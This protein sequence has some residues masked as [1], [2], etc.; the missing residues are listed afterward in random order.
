M[1]KRRLTATLSCLLLASASTAGLEAATAT[2]DLGATDRGSGLENTQ[3]DE[4]TDGE[5]DA[6][7]CG[8]AGREREVRRNRGPGEAADP[9]IYLYFRVAE[10][11]VKS[12]RA[13]RVSATFFDDPAFAASPV[14]VRLQYTNAAA[15]GPADIPD[16][17]ASHPRTWTLGGSGQWVRHVWG[18]ADAGFR[19]FMQ[20]TSDFRLVLGGR[21]C[22]D[23][24]EVTAE[25]EFV[26][27][28]HVIGAHYYPWFDGGRW[29]YGE[30]ASGALRLEL[31]P[32]Q[33][34][35]LGRYSSATP[36]VVDQHLRWCAEHGVNLLILEYI[37]PG[38]REDRNVLDVL[39]RSPRRDDVQYSVLYDWAIRFGELAATPARIAT[40]VQDFDHLAERYF[41]QPT[42]F[43]VRGE[44][45][46]AM[47]YVTR[48]LSGDV[49]GFI[50]AVR[51]VC[52]A[53]GHD[54]FLVGDEFFFIQ[55][56]SA[57][58]IA[59]WDG[60]FGYDVYASRGGYWGENGALDLFRSRT[61]AY[62][63]AARAARVLFI[64]S[65]AP[66][67]NDRAIRRTCADHPA[68]PRQLASGDEPTSL[69]REVF[70]GISL[71]RVDAAVPLV[72]I[73][74][75]NE[76]HEDT[77]IEP[78]AGGTGGTAADSSPS[79]S[80]YTQGFA[81]ADYG[82][83]FLELIRDATIAVTGRVLGIDGRPA[84]GAAVDVLEG[85]S[86]DTVVLTRKA[87][88][89]GIYTIPRLRL[90]P[91]RS[92]RLRVRSP[93]LKDV[94]SEPF[95]PGP[96]TITGFDLAF[97]RNAPPEV[98]IEKPT[99][100]ALFTPAEPIPIA[101]AAADA[102]GTVERVEI[103]AD[104][105]PLASAVE[106]PYE[107][108]WETA[109]EGEHLI[110]A[111]AVDDL[112]EAAADSVTVTVQ[113]ARRLP[114]NC[115]RDGVVD[116]SDGVCVLGFLFAGT[117]AALPCG[118]GEA[119]HPANLALLDWQPDGR[120][121]LSDGVA[122]LQFLFGGGRAHHLA[123]PGEE[124]TTC[125]VIAGCTESGLCP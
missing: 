108:A 34:P 62:V 94:V 110:T 31:R 120:I 104:G 8:P 1:V 63:A 69:F 22:T 99:E 14:E 26:P 89:T 109:A 64:P 113:A 98:E 55:A 30:C 100:G 76:W 66:G 25:G 115:N 71:S 105:D 61:D 49:D 74:S 58:R 52:A 73:T 20:G 97:R 10:P 60:I 70:A 38:G 44:R 51:E 46:L 107:F 103:L 21:A 41:T 92:H 4:G 78:T 42:Y 18:L 67:F 72:S 117:P 23:R 35:R 124:S 85:A 6:L 50:G 87:F 106:P 17:F 81:H 56:P 2:V 79:G 82:L 96:A 29:N 57:A 19:D 45:P 86:G 95:A 28:E 83:A 93:G 116:V 122:L 77:Q 65:C 13:L 101:V 48:A 88:S 59:R 7:T 24:V 102:D 68:L 27:E 33:S 15:T 91:G 12:A 3:R 123:A 9:D 121:D 40:A 43:K 37:A 114:G 111:R 53:R 5:N 32:P 119:T 36:S 112:G 118:D 11:A 39:F 125:V 84:P 75:F 90:A 16:T 80:A 47:V 54:V